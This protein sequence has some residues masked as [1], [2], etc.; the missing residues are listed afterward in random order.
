MKTKTSG[1]L[2]TSQSWSAGLKWKHVL[3]L[4]NNARAA[5]GQPLFASC[6]RGDQ[7]TANEQFL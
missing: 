5:I 4:G 2:D 3:L 6:L 7:T 1:Q